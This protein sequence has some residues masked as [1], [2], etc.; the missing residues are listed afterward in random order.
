M[1][2]IVMTW[3]FL[4]GANMQAYAEF[5]KKSIGTVLQAPGFVEFRANRN[6]LGSPQVRA[7]WV[8]QSKADWANYADSETGV[9]LLAEGQKYITNFHTEIWGPSPRVPEPVRAKR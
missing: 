7:T 3:D 8:W 5:A 1:V 6:A 2:E 4:P 9:A